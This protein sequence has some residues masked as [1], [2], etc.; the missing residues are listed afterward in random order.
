MLSGDEISPFIVFRPTH[1]WKSPSWLLPLAEFS[2]AVL[3]LTLIAWPLAALA[4]R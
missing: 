1:W 2:L 3:L 4:R